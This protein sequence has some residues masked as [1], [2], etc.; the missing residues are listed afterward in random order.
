MTARWWQKHLIIFVLSAVGV[1]IVLVTTSLYGPGLSAD[2]AAYLSAAENLSHGKGLITY[3]GGQLVLWPPLF[4]SLLAL[5]NYIGLPAIEAARWLNALSF[6]LIVFVF[7]MLLIN[8]IDCFAVV[9]L[10]TGAVLLSPVLVDIS[11]MAWTE[12]LFILFVLLWIMQMSQYRRTRYA[13][14]LI[15]AGV[16]AALTCLTRYVGVTVVAAGAILLLLEPVKAI[17]KRLWR[18]AAYVV[19]SMLPFGLWLG[20]NLV[21]SSTLMG[22]RASGQATVVQNIVYTLQVISL[23]FL[24]R[25][26]PPLAR[27]IAVALM[28][29]ALAATLVIARR[30]IAG[31]N[32]QKLAVTLVPVVCFS[33]VYIAFLVV[34][35]AAFGIDPISNR[36]LSPLYVPLLLVAAIGLETAMHLPRNRLHKK[37]LAGALLCGFAVWLF[38]PLRRTAMMITTRMASGAGG[39]STERWRTSDLISKLLQ[40]SLRGQVYSNDPAVLYLLGGIN[41][42][43]SPRKY[44]LGSPNTPVDELP[45][46][47]KSLD[48]GL[49]TYLVW[50]GKPVPGRQF[51]PQELSRV[52]RLQPYMHA[53]DGTVYICAA[54]QAGPSLNSGEW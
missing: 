53:L 36:L 23:W 11:T 24:P 30:V 26:V 48:T 54:T 34:S 5:G 31:K 16:F 21:V 32:Y 29:A 9:L 8:A 45:R 47:V 41:A 13:A 12:P 42:Q 27:V 46:F 38:L 40:T 44:A 7:G 28:F 1:T 18:V 52:C 17:H 2:S 43:W 39:Y 35:A 3:G 10:A 50:V 6:G 19:L 49:R 4:P 15:L 22:P 14:P 33:I 25:S 20:R 51:T 37:L